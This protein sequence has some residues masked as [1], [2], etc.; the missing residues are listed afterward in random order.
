MK[1]NDMRT[2]STA[3]AVAGALAVGALG[4]YVAGAA[5]SPQLALGPS[6]S[7]RSETMVGPMMSGRMGGRRASAMSKM[8]DAEQ[9]KMMRDPATGRLGDR[10]M[11]NAPAM[12]AMMR[13]HMSGM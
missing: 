10:A 11:K 7:A 8:M 1:E 9:A 3:V 4:S 2:R 12:R 6:P 13:E 5:G